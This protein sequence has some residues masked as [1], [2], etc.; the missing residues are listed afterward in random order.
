M[1]KL[2]LS[3]LSIVMAL[4]MATQV[5]ADKLQDILDNGVV[6]IA[7]SL[8][9]PPFGSLGPDGQPIGLDIELANMVAEA[10]GVQLQLEGVASAARVAMLASDRADIVISN[11]GLTPERAKQVLYTAPYVNTVQGIFGP[12]DLAVSSLDDLG[13]YRISVV[14]GAGATVAIETNAPQANLLQFETDSDSATAFMTGQAEL[15]GSS[16]VTVGGIKAQNPDRDIELK[17]A[18]RY[19]PAHMAVRLGEQNLQSWLNSFIYYHQLSGELNRLSETYLDT[20]METL[21][22]PLPTL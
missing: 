6:K 1:K 12:S 4:G 8:D 22:L 21:S 20:P 14:R 10:L 15:L 11:L 2:L 18:L 9:S 16:N 13:S 5:H 3:T 7:V 17:V 19:S